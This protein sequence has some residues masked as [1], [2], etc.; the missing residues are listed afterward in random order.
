MRSRGS[1]RRATRDW[2][3]TRPR[4]A[5]TATCPGCAARR[6]PW[7]TRR[8]VTMQPAE[9]LREDAAA[10]RTALDVTRSF[11]VHAPAGSGKTELL[12]QRFL[13]L[14]AVVERP[15]ALLAITFTRKAAAEM[16]N[17][18]LEAL[19]QCGDPASKL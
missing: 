5:G 18:I 8:R 4:P 19:R 13:A 6:K 15:E 10:R 9:L 11:I 3:R 1:T 12:T 14:L 2:R 17:R 7:P 16:R